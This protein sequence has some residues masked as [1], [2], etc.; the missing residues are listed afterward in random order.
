MG[1]VPFAHDSDSTTIVLSDIWS[2][3]KYQMCGYFENVYGQASA[4]SHGLFETASSDNSSKYVV[5]FG[6]ALPAD[7]SDEVAKS[8]SFY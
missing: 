7:I 4:V 8:L 2:G 6:G 5:T 1:A 3:T